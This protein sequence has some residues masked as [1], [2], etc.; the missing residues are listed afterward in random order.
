MC[1]LFAYDDYVAAAAAAV[2]VAGV[3]GD[4]DDGGVDDADVVVGVA[5]GG[6]D[7]CSDCRWRGLPWRCYL[8]PSWSSVLLLLV[9]LL[10]LLWLMV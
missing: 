4:D 6:A 10:L 7:S 5:V 9:L 8:W 1:P 3:G 2:V